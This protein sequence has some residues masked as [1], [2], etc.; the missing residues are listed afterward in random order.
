M[1][2]QV[3]ATNHDPKVV[4]RFYLESVEEI[5]GMKYCSKLGIPKYLRSDY[6]TENCVIASIYIAFHLADSTGLR[7]NS[8]IWTIEK[9]RGRHS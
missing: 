1:W 5:G 8:Y 2:L 7:Q 4:S 9:E 6:G 3:T